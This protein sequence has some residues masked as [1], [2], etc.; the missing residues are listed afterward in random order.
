MEILELRLGN[1]GVY[2]GLNYSVINEMYRIV[3]YSDSAVG[4]SSASVKFEFN[5]G[6]VHFFCKYSST[7]WL[8]NAIFLAVRY[9]SKF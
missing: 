1:N 2:F 6:T 7:E 5:R 4:P 3:S 9:F 8:R